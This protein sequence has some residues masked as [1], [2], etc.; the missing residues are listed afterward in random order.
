MTGQD[1]T[2]LTPKPVLFLAFP[3][4]TNDFCW[5]Q[6]FA[7]PFQQ[8]VWLTSYL[9]AGSSLARLSTCNFFSTRFS[10]T[11]C[12]EAGNLVFLAALNSLQDLGSPT[13]D[14]TWA[15]AVKALRANQ[16][17]AREF[18]GK[19]SNPVIGLD[20]V[21]LVS[22]SSQHPA[23]FQSYLVG[24]SVNFALFFFMFKEKNTNSHK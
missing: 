18:P 7:R 3:Q 9:W 10:L 12:K 19:P 17:P 4:I 23:S 13:R 21:G 11:G 16:W 5:N 8:A 6:I 15:T 14:W 22:V 24:R 20:S 1:S 2:H